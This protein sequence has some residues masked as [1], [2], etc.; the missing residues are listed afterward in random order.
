LRPR[1]REC[2]TDLKIHAHVEG[3]LL[4]GALV[5]VVIELL[6]AREVDEHLLEAGQRLPRERLGVD[7]HHARLAPHGCRLPVCV[8]RQ[9]RVDWE[10][11][12]WSLGL[13][14]GVAMAI[15]EAL[16]WHRHLLDHPSYRPSIAIPACVTLGS[17][18]GITIA[19]Q[20]YLLGINRRVFMWLTAC[21]IALP[22][23]SPH[24][25][26]Q[27]RYCAPKPT[28]SMDFID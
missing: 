18:D 26:P 16:E 23:T 13:T 12:G 14:L 19:S 10:A 9:Q 1:F 22:P 20:E 15:S 17:E 2:G 3:A 28:I 11:V 7:A 21:G 6:D 24:T 25:I 27:S 4:R 8:P 5:V